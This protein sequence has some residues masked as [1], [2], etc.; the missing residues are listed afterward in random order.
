MSSKPD[1]VKLGNFR[2]TKLK[3]IAMERIAPALPKQVSDLSKFKFNK[4]PRSSFGM[5]TTDEEALAKLKAKKN[6]HFLN[7]AGDQESTLFYYPC[8]M[9]NCEQIILIRGRIDEDRL[10]L[11]RELG[12]PPPKKGGLR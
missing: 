9:E 5:I 12:T 6:G 7:K 11:R 10:L 1:G 2:D 8:E 4:A 3:T